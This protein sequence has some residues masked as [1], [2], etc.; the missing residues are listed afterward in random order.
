MR[1]DDGRGDSAGPLSKLALLVVMLTVMTILAVNWKTPKD[2]ALCADGEVEQWSGY[3][4]LRVKC[5]KRK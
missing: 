1:H 2:N 5:V 4:V 3:K